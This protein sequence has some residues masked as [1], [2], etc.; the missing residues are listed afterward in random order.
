MGHHQKRWADKSSCEVG[1][2]WRL[3]KERI[4]HQVEEN[5]QNNQQKAGRA[6]PVA[7]IYPFRVTCQL[8]M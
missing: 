6:E 7:H 8:W 4:R 1:G 5:E 3:R 2:G